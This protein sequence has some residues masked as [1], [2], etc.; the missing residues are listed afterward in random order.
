M[1]LFTQPRL[2]LNSSRQPSGP[3]TSVDFVIRDGGLVA[4]VELVGASQQGRFADLTVSMSQPDE[5]VVLVGAMQFAVPSSEKAVA[6]LLEDLWPPLRSAIALAPSELRLKAAD[7]GLGQ[8]R[9]SRVAAAH[10]NYQ[11]WDRADDRGVLPKT[12]RMWRFLSDLGSSRPAELIA[13]ALEEKVPTIH[14]RINLARAQGLIPPAER[15]QGSHR[16][17]SKRGDKN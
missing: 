12:A 1:E 15:T 11:V 17:S 13:G 8:D 4:V 2:P 7:R 16:S 10:L 5:D 14:A 3:P 9:L 6:T